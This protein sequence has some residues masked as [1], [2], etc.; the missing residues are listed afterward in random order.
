MKGAPFRA[1]KEEGG[2][3]VLLPGNPRGKAEHKFTASE[4]AW[5]NAKGSQPQNAG[6]VPG[7]AMA[8]EGGL[9]ERLP[10]QGWAHLAGRSWSR[11]GQAEGLCSGEGGKSASPSGQSPSASAG[12]LGR[13]WPP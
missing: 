12:W 6:G 1:R 11:A 8:T 13:G 2:R 3:F 9:M 5:D 7:F 10:L 4:V